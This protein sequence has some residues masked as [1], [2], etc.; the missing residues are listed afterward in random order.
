MTIK[1]F[2]LLSQS[3]MSLVQVMIA[4]A[5]T[6]VLA[7]VIMNLTEQ[8]QMQQ[9]TALSNADIQEVVGHFNTILNNKDYCNNTFGPVKLGGTIGTL[10]YSSDPDAEPFAIAGQQF[11]KSKVQIDEMKVE[12]FDPSQDVLDSNGEMNLRFKVTMRKLGKKIL[13]GKQF[14]KTWSPRVMLG[15]ISDEVTDY[16]ET[17]K[18]QCL[19]KSAN[20]KLLS[21]KDGEEF[22]S[23]DETKPEEWCEYANHPTNA[24]QT[25]AVVG[26][27]IPATSSNLA[28]AVIHKC[29]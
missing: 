8:M 17:S 4:F 19:A 12:S 15:E 14:V 13:G 21:L 2:K 6:G 28:N 29:L 22:S 11:K 25:V 26:C 10:R 18:D 1:K 20:A 9:N 7:V 27:F 23:G 24:S 5:L 3:G 16:C